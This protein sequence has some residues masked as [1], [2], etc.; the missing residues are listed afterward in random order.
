M[1]IQLNQKDKVVFDESTLSLSIEI[2]GVRWQWDTS[3]KPFISTNY[4]DFTFENARKIEH[5]LWDT[6][7]GKGIHSSYSDFYVDNKR[8][9]LS[10]ET[11]IWIEEITQNIICEFIPDEENDIEIRY[12]NWP[13]Y[14]EFTKQSAEW[15]TL[16]NIQ[17][18]LLVPNNWPVEFGNLVLDGC[19]TSVAAFLPWFAQIK[20]RK[21]YIAICET[22]WDA[23]YYVKHP[24]EGG[25]T[26]VGIKWNSSLGRVAYKRIARYVFFDDCDY[27][28]ITK[29][30][31]QYAK[32][33]GYF[34]TLEEKSIRVPKVKEFIGCSVVH[35]YAKLHID[36]SSEL[37]DSSKEMDKLVTFEEIGNQL[38]E[39]HKKGIK[40]V[41]L[42]L[43]GWGNRG[44]DNLHPD[45]LPV[46][47]EAG[48]TSGLCELIERAHHFGYLV[49]L[50]DQYRDYFFKAPSFDIQF[51]C[52]NIDG[53]VPM[54]R[55]W[56]GGRQTLLCATQAPYYVKRNY[57]RLLQEGIKPDAVYLDV[58]TCHEGEECFH[59]LHKMTRK[60]CLEYR[61]ECLKF[62][63]AKNIVASSEDAAEWAM[64]DQVIVHFSPYEFMMAKKSGIPRRGIP[65][66]LFNLVYHECLI[67]PWFMDRFE[68]DYMLHALI[69]G[70]IPYLLRE[71]PYEHSDG[72]VNNVAEI[73]FEEQIKRSRVVAKFHEL[74]ALSEL[75]RHEFVGGNPKKQKS[76]FSNGASVEVDFEKGT[77]KINYP[78]E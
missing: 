17:Q 15:Y 28:D 3:F 31:R 38:E 29:Y 40:K 64:Q 72:R 76:V 71:K 21:G 14:M 24:E 61:N 41:Y 51:A 57:I 37:Y 69:N 50:H 6:G 1:I 36:E 56:A 60:E 63:M 23:A 12:I 2:R 66:P 78:Y 33:K 27:N 44:Y 55:R 77:Y 7:L 65:I 52:Y 62:I 16:L 42:H 59:P 19:F 74:V 25:Y 58:F 68:E 75:V 26:N 4:G 9:P 10:F 49:G 13:G 32:E 18:G 39:Y 46:N 67:I 73:S 20:Q 48:G 45:Y 34:C 54:E 43:D 8:I 11:I 30:Y 53:T 5:H 70:G 47:K 35:T 22:P